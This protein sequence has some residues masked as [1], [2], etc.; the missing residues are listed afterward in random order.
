MTTEQAIEH[1]YRT[2]TSVFD[3]DGK[4]VG[5]IREQARSD[6]HLIVEKGWLF[7]ETVEIPWSAIHARD[8]K[9]IY[10]KLSREELKAFL[11]DFEKLRPLVDAA[12]QQ[13]ADHQR[14]EQAERERQFQKELKTALSPEARDALGIAYAWDHEN[15]RPQATFDLWTPRQLLIERCTITQQSETKQW[16]VSLRSGSYLVEGVPGD[17]LQQ[18]VLVAIGRHWEAA[19]RP[20]PAELF[21]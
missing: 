18:E 2:G 4:K 6:E 8:D 1:P 3:R 11:A 13:E 10:L 14:A 15:A 17:I 19:Q 12:V 9:G 20:G 21:S 16:S 5:A 7:P